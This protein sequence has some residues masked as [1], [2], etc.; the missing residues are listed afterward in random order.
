MNNT[1]LFCGREAKGR[2]VVCG[3]VT[4]NEELD[5]FVHCD[6]CDQIMYTFTGVSGKRELIDPG[7]GDGATVM[8]VHRCKGVSY[9]WWRWP[10]VWVLRWVR[11]M[12]DEPTWRY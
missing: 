2:C 4:F 11:K 6:G 10:I 8:H 1:C 9:V 7:T 5:G 12:F 3:G